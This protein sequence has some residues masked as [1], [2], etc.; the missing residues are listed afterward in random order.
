[1]LILSSTIFFNKH[2]LRGYKF[3]DRVIERV[4]GFPERPWGRNECVTNEPQRTSVGRLGDVILD[5]GIFSFALPLSS[6]IIPTQAPILVWG[7]ICHV[8]LIIAAILLASQ[9]SMY[10]AVWYNV[11]DLVVTQ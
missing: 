11:S 2:L 6:I 7:K 3:S 9:N 10:V 8:A 4:A 1:M 5:L